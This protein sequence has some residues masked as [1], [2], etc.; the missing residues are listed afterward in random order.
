MGLI[1]YDI[2]VS[3]RILN[4]RSKGGN[5]RIIGGKHTWIRPSGSSNDTLRMS[6]GLPNLLAKTLS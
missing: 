4:K 1:T 6:T 3:H 5:V 2:Y